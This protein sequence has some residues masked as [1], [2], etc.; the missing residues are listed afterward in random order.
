MRPVRTIAE[1]ETFA[2]EIGKIGKPYG[3]EHI[4]RCYLD[5]ALGRFESS[6]AHLEV[7]RANPK[8][9]REG[10]EDLHDKLMAMAAALE[11]GDRKRIS[12]FLHECEAYTVKQLKLE[13]LWQPS[14]FPIELEGQ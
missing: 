14:P 5:A 8:F 11:T 1:F 9:F 4:I 12:A 13:K 2:F 3:G 10:R 6:L 7:M